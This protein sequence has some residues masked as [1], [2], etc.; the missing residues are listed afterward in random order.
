MEETYV[1]GMTMVFEA[2]NKFIFMPDLREKLMKFYRIYWGVLVIYRILVKCDIYACLLEFLNKK[3]EGNLKVWSD[4]YSDY[5]FS[6]LS[7]PIMWYYSES[8][9]LMNRCCGSFLTS[10]LYPYFVSLI[11][12]KL[13]SSQRWPGKPTGP[14]PP[15]MLTAYDVNS[16]KFWG[17]F[18]FQIY[19]QK[20]KIFLVFNVLSGDYYAIFPSTIIFLLGSAWWRNR[21]ALFSPFGPAFSCPHNQAL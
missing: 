19:P 8:W 13:S 5:G 7:Y 6:G 12:S 2:A 18:P 10:K 9:F 16:N 20:I 4:F 17:V 21:R 15:D 11:F 14:A 1:S 3:A